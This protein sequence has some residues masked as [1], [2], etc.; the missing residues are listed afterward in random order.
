MLLFQVGGEIRLGGEGIGVEACGSMITFFERTEPG[1]FDLLSGTIWFLCPSQDGGKPGLQHHKTLAL[2]QELLE[3]LPLWLFGRQSVESFFRYGQSIRKMRLFEQ[4]AA[5]VDVRQ[6]EIRL[7]VDGPAE[8]RDG[9]IE[10]ALVKQEF[11]RLK[12][13][14]DDL[15][16]TRSSIESER[17]GVDRT[18][19]SAVARFNEQ[20]RDYN[21][22]ASQQ[23]Q[24]ERAYNASAR[25]YEQERQQLVASFNDYQ[26]LHEAYR[27][28]TRALQQAYVDHRTGVE[29][30]KR[31]SSAFEQRRDA[32]NQA[33]ITLRDDF[34][35]WKQRFDAY[36]QK[37]AS[38][39]KAGKGARAEND[40]DSELRKAREDARKAE[41]ERKRIEKELGK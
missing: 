26:R 5:K 27:A 41:I 8:A 16:R 4:H 6:G 15:R 7:V 35:S 18:N 3:L 17:S 29:D 11:A 31:R 10:V 20:V 19:P 1:E 34:T 37:S 39:A 13:T 24:A 2:L 21:A 9:S 32:Y 33:R 38:T 23:T 12:N 25:A 40:Q 28:R 36:Q 14:A 30:Y 22:R